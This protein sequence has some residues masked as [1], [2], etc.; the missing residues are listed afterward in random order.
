MDFRQSVAVVSGSNRGLGLELAAQL[1]ER[2]AKT[3]YATGRDPGT[4]QTPGATPLGLDITDQESV[5]RAA[6]IAGDAM[7]VVNNAGIWTG[8]GLTDGDLA[9]PASQ[10]WR[11][12]ASRP[13]SPK[14]W[15]TTSLATSSRVS[16]LGYGG[17]QVQAST[18]SSSDAGSTS[19]SCL[20][21]VIPSFVN[22]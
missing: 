8:A 1:L 18:S 12:T 11:C 19:A 20:R 22:T 21:E 14:S 17:P 16:Q 4:V 3:V 5:A 6:A 13:T 10:R 9:W 7:L 2:G 15:P